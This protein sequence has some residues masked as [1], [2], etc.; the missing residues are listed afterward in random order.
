[1]NKEIEEKKAAIKNQRRVNIKY[2]KSRWY[3]SG[4]TT[5]ENLIGELDVLEKEWLDQQSK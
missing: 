1:M 5:L 4:V 3:N 2:S